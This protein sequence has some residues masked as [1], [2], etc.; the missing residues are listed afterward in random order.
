MTAC[1]PLSR[2]SSSMPGQVISPYGVTILAAPLL[3]KAA[4]VSP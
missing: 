3:S 2:N 4:P 1:G